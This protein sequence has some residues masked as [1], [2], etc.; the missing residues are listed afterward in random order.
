MIAGIINILRNKTELTVMVLLALLCLLAINNPTVQLKKSITSYMLLVDVSQS[1]NAE[2][3]LVKDSPVTRIEY[4]KL[5]LKNIIDRSDCG[6]FFSINI[7]VADNI[8]NI[9]EPVEKCK[10][11]DELMDTISKLEWRMA[12]KGNSRITFGIKSA[13]K[14]QDSLNFPSK[15][16]FFTDGDEAPKVNAINRVN[17]DD[18]NLGEELIF[19]GIGGNVPVPVK[20]YNSR[21]MY[22]GYWGSDIYDSLPGAT[23]SRNSDSGKDEP[24]PSVA[25]ADYER[26]LT[27]LYE[28]YLISLSEQIKSQYIKGELSDTFTKKILDNRP[29][30]KIQSDFQLERPAIFIGLLLIV[31]LHLRRKL[32][33]LLSLISNR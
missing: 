3:L 28:D 7:F 16:L 8:A 23:G 24:D 31:A 20:R 25:S 22:V 5:L 19:V 4:T 15:I 17:L 27:K 30:Q 32:T 21:N 2:D 11:Y 26:Y 29:H 33:A 6:S 14:M 18:F 1:M 13:A 9:I 12:W 10:N